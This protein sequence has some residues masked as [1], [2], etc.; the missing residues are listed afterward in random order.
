MIDTPHHPPRLLAP[1]WV[2]A[3]C[4]LLLVGTALTVAGCASVNRS[5]YAFNEGVRSLATAPLRALGGGKGGKG[6]SGFPTPSSNHPIPKAL[7]GMLRNL[8]YGDVVLN[9]ALQ[10]NFKQADCAMR[11]WLLN[12]I[13]GFGGAIDVATAHGLPE[14][15]EDFG[16]T[17]AV[18]GVP[19]GPYLVL[20][21]SGP[22]TP[23]HL[24][25]YATRWLTNPFTWVAAPELVLATRGMSV[26]TGA[27]RVG[28]IM[29]G[30]GG[31]PAGRLS[32]EATQRHYFATRRALI[33]GQCP[34]PPPVPDIPACP[35]RRCTP[36][37]APP[38]PAF[39]DAP[40]TAVPA[41]THVETRTTPAHPF[42]GPPPLRSTR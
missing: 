21:F 11:R 19:A 42:A 10:G 8:T 15:D 20:P 17:L 6:A 34:P 22:T 31:R 37:C 36:R 3:A 39:A 1:L 23:R 41:P 2:R 5:V 4:V 13:A 30:E 38:P 35:P 40:P 29:R 7:G 18:W 27:G 33:C 16:Q 12:T 24:A 26:V 9:S 28:D 14:H 32:Y 25:G